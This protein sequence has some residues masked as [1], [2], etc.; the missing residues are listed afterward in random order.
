MARRRKVTTWWLRW[1][2]LRERWMLYRGRV[3]WEEMNEWP[4]EGGGSR[5]ATKERSIRR[6]ARAV[7]SWAIENG[8]APARLNIC[9]VG[10]GNRILLERSYFCDR[11]DRKG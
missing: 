3:E 1:H 9:G 2:A 11:K 10:T 6:A 7:R 5:S 4:A 8:K